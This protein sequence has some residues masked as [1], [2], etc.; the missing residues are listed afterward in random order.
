MNAYIKYFLDEFT[1]HSQE[2][3][4]MDAIANIASRITQQHNL[5]YTKDFQIAETGID[6]NGRQW[7]K[8]DFAKEE[9][10]MLVRLKGLENG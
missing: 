10:A 3:A 5:I 4:K 2:F 6:S 9:T 8:F 7:A 1:I